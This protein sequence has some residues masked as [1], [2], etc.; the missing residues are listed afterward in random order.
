MSI[1]PWD[2]DG[3]AMSTAETQT[4]TRRN[5]RET[6]R[7]IEQLIASAA[8][9]VGR[10]ARRAEESKRRVAEQAQMLSSRAG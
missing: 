7:Q 10:V 4:L 2:H 1:S 9:A 3:E 6:D 8:R 5:T